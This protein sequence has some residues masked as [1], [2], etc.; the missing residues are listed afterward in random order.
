MAR[1]DASASSSLTFFASVKP[2]HQ[3]IAAGVL[4]PP[5]VGALAN[6][7][8]SLTVGVALPPS[9]TTSPAREPQPLYIDSSPDS[10][11]GP[12]ALVSHVT[13]SRSMYSLSALSI[14]SD[15]TPCSFSI[16]SS[17][18]PGANSS[19]SKPAYMFTNSAARSHPGLRLAANAFCMMPFSR[20]T[21]ALESTSS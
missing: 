15:F 20:S 13:K 10:H 18:E 12:T 14:S 5:T 1:N 4:P 21:S 16:A 7:V 9:T 3:S 17:A 8:V 2:S 6:R 11:I 19:P